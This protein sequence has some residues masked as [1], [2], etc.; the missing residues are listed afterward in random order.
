MYYNQF[1][2][3]LHSLERRMEGMTASLY[4][5]TDRVLVITSYSYL[6]LWSE[7]T[8]LVVLSFIFFG[9]IL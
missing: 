9:Q 6:L 1:Q 5:T 2:I 7:S 3:F 4:G 8:E